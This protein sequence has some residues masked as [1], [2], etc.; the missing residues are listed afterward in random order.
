MSDTYDAYIGEIRIFAGNYAPDGWLFCNGQEVPMSKYNKLY[1]VIGNQYG[2]S[3]PQTFALPNLSGRVPIHQGHGPGLTPRSINDKGGE[4]TVGLSVEQIP[5]HTHQANG[6]AKPGST[7][8]GS[9][10]IWAQGPEAGR[11]PIS[12]PFYSQTSNVSMNPKA[13]QA[14]GD[15]QPHNNMQAFLALNFIISVEGEFPNA[16]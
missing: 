14:T 5:N 15:N 4:P 9:G 6:Y 16:D 3:F 13:L 2:G 8:A 7:T 10:N 1:T 12:A 11:P